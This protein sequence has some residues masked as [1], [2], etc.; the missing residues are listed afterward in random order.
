[1]RATD[2]DWR[3]ISNGWT[4]EELVY[5]R[6]IFDEKIIQCDIASIKRKTIIRKQED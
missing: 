3:S 4:R 1:M 6:S 5:V 2:L